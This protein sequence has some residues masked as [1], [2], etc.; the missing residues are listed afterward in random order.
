MSWTPLFC[1]GTLNSVMTPVDEIVPTLLAACST[2]HMLP[3]LSF[4]M[5][6]GSLLGVGMGYSEITPVSTLI[7]AILSDLDSV[8]HTSLVAA[9]PVHMPIGTLLGV[10]IGYS[11]IEPVGVNRPILLALDSVNQ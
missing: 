8:N 2:N 1:V 10:E 6:T 7:E 3:S 5:L 11:V 9:S 4:E